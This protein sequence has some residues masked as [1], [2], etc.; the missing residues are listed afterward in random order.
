MESDFQQH[1]HRGWVLAM[2]VLL[3]GAA[4]SQPASQPASMPVEEDPEFIEFLLMLEEAPW[5][6]P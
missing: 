3:V 2:M 1:P 6:F 4:S 5:L